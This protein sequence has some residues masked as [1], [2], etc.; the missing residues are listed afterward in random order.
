VR[1]AMG[2]RFP[3]QRGGSGERGSMAV[4]MVLLAPVLL[5]FVLVVVAFGRYVAIR[6]DVEAASRDAVRA[7]SFERTSSSAGDA[8]SLT[9]TAS[10]NPKWKCS[11]TNLQ[12]P[13]GFT[14]G[15][16]VSITLSCQVPLSDL[17]LIGLKGT[18]TVSSTSEAP[19]DRYRRTGP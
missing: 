14:A 6:G 15:Q 11:D 10:L 3:G 12:D 1:V 18:K 9:A 16:I 8:A 2:R 4:E 7:A 13:D 17:G 19:L 5:M